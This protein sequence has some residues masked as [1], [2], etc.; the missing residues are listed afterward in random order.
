MKINEAKTK[1]MADSKEKEA[2]LIVQLQ[3]AKRTISIWDSV[4][5]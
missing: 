1:L 4:I 2:R 5:I 3:S